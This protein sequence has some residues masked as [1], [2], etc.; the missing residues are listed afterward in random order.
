MESSS[1]GQSPKGRPLIPA[2]KRLTVEG[3]D[4]PLDRDFKGTIPKGQFRNV[5]VS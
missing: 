5:S 4:H 1:P 2:T 3:E